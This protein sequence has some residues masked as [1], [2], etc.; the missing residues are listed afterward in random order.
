MLSLPPSVRI[1]VARDCVDMRKSVDGLSELARVVIEEN[2]QSG[3]LFVFF[4]RTKD[5]TKILWWDRS[6]YF[7]ALQAARSRSLPSPR[8][9]G[10]QAAC[11]RA[12]SRRVGAASRRHRSARRAASTHARR[13]LRKICLAL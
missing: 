1:F 5:R 8:S 2:P 4:N 7:P 3:H 9:H 12:D 6:G 10:A 11:H 13:S